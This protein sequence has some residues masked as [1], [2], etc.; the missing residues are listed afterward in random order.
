MSCSCPCLCQPVE[1]KAPCLTIIR[2]FK[3]GTEEH[4]MK[5]RGSR[6][7][8][9]G[10][11]TP[12]PQLLPWWTVTSNCFYLA[13]LTRFLVPRNSGTTTGSSVERSQQ[14]L[15]ENIKDISTPASVCS[16]GP[17]PQQTHPDLATNCLPR[18]PRHLWPFS[19]W[20]ASL[21]WLQHTDSTL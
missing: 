2:G 19:F 6:G 7:A 4:E 15:K 1:R 10:Y 9:P 14:R 11:T 17:R 3:T 12:Y 16:R 5:C 21:Q 20:H 13:H 8:G 18:L